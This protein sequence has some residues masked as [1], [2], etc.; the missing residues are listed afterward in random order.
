MAR[1]KGKEKKK[2][3]NK[4]LLIFISAVILAAIAGYIA[5]I[6]VQLPDVSIIGYG[7]PFE[8]TEIYSADGE[9]LASIHKDENRSIVP[10][11]EIS[12]YLQKAV[13][14]SEDER[15]F[16][17]HGIDFRGITRAFVTNILTGHISEGGSTITQQLARTLFL[18]LNK[19]VTRKIAEIILALQIERKYTKEEIFEL[20]LNHT[21][22]GHNAYGAESASNIL[23]GKHAADLTLG[24]AAMMAGIIKAP[25]FYSPYKSLKFAKTKQRMVL[26]KMVSQSYISQSQ[27]YAALKEPIVLK[28]KR[29]NKYKYAAPYFTTYVLAQLIEQFGFDRVY[30]GGLRVYTTLDMKDQKNAEDTVELFKKNESK[31]YNFSEIALL[32]I[33]TRTGEIKAMVGGFDFDKSEFN[34]ATQAKRPTGSSFKPFVYAAAIEKGLSPT[35]II[36]DG[37]TSFDVPVTKWTPKGKW[38]PKNFDKKYRG[39]VT[40]RYALENSLN[41]PSVK[42][43]QEVGIDNAIAMAKKAGIKGELVNGLSLALGTSDLT[44]LDMTSAFGT[45]ANLG[46]HAKPY[47]ISKILGR[48]GELIFKNEP[49]LNRTIDENVAET[50]VDIMRGVLT[51][52]T[53]YK[54]R[55]NR[56]AAAKTGTTQD[57]KDAWFIGFVPQLVT[58][59]WVGNDNNTPMRGIAEVAVCPR[60]WKTYME[61]TLAGIEVLDFPRPKVMIEESTFE[62]N[63]VINQ[64]KSNPPKKEPAQKTEEFDID[65][66]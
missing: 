40:M 42:L 21:Y 63:S 54:G 45:F 64:P 36:I 51:K 49:R 5:Q 7:A 35:H 61:K 65:V 15:F 33:D 4:I 23:F 66:Q 8:N 12:P 2:S 56:P 11:S 41:I 59:V 58:G 39:P 19:T 13:I 26:G 34:R 48:N 60:I 6:A 50:T 47:S 53:G 18:N 44:L 27:E 31:K 38:E 52:G 22:W 16:S 24:E 43:L 25:E 17:H 32:S 57:Y 1:K 37:P 46:I 29:L 30:K 62:S 10:L 28:M 14:A 9:I 55:I 20:Y 3:R